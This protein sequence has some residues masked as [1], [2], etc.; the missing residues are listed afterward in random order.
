MSLPMQEA[1]YRARACGAAQF[2]ESGNGNMQIAVPFEIVDDDEFTGEVITWFAT[3][4]GTPDKKGKTGKDRV[5]ESLL[6]MGWQGDDLTELMEISD[7]E[8]RALM[9]EVVELVC[10]PDEYNGEWRL[11][12]RW[13][14]KPGAGRASFKEPLSK[15]GMKAFAAQMRNSLKNARGGQT[16]PSNGQRSQ[17][18]HPNAPRGG[19]GYGE[20][21]PD[22]DIPFATADIAH[23]PSPI[24]KV[25]R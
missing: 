10:A 12:V 21:P 4:H 9:P 3:M 25:L 8:A 17:Q 13:V 24:A 23:E 20:P 19:G 2:E 18:P 6:H 14:N 22:D 15:D 7:N 11:K 16:R 1:R 5:I